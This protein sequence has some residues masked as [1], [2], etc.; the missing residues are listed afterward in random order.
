MAV[1][2]FPEL[3]PQQVLGVFHLGGDTVQIV[4]QDIFH[5][6]SQFRPERFLVHWFPI[7][8]LAAL[9][10]AESFPLFIGQVAVHNPVIVPGF[11]AEFAV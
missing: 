11:P 9:S 1:S 7:T 2:L 8:G 4:P 5:D 10:L 3:F 6:G